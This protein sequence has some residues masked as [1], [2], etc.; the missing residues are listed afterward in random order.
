[1][2]GI[3]SEGPG[4]RPGEASSWQ[5]QGGIGESIAGTHLPAWFPSFLVVECWRYKGG[6]VFG[7]AHCPWQVPPASPSLGSGT[8]LPFHVPKRPAMS[9]EANLRLWTDGRYLMYTSNSRMRQRVPGR[10]SY[11]TAS[12]RIAWLC[13]E[14]TG[15]V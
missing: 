1:M 15:Q 5:Q 11:W 9:R 12:V 7:D 4:P 10:A 2:A 8:S 14:G 13:V 3:W 6:Y